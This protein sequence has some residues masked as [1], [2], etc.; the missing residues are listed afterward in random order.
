MDRI[1]HE[2]LSRCLFEESN[3][4]FFIIDPADNRTLDANP[5]AQR[6]TGMRRKQLL[7][8]KLADLLRADVGR[9]VD[10]LIDAYQSTRVFHSEEGYFL[11]SANGDLPINIS[12]SRIHTTP[13]PL[14]LVV[15]RDITRRKRAE[16]ILKSSQR[17]LEI[18]FEHA[19]DAYYLNDLEGNFVDGNKAAE[20]ISGFKKEELIGKNFFNLN[21]LPSTEIPKAAELLKRNALGQTTGPDELVLNRQDGDQVHVEIRTF[22][23][24]IE[25]KDLVL[26]ISRDVTERKR[27]EEELQRAHDELEIRVRQRTTELT[28]ANRR[29]REEIEGRN[30]AAEAQRLME[31][32]LVL[33]RSA[34]HFGVWEWD[35]QTN[36]LELCVEVFT[37]LGLPTDHPQPSMDKFFEWIHPDDRDRVMKERERGLVDVAPYE[38]EY[39]VVWPDDSVHWVMGKG[40]VLRDEAGKPIRALGVLF[41]ITARK[42]A[43]LELKLAKEK[44][45]LRVQERTREL[46]AANLL[47]NLE[48]KE[49]GRAENEARQHLTELAHFG[50]V[51]TIGEMASG[52]SHELNQPLTAIALESEICVAK[53]RQGSAGSDERLLSRLE[54]INDQAHRAGEIIRLLK[55]FTRRAEPCLSTADVNELVRDM[56]QLTDSELQNHNIVTRLELGENLPEVLLDHVQ[57]MQVLLNLVRNAVEAMQQSEPQARFLTIRTEAPADGTIT[58]SVSDTGA[59]IAAGDLERIFESFYTT[60][61]S[62]TGLGLAISRSLIEAHGGRLWANPNATV[63]STLTLRLPIGEKEPARGI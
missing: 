17:R 12:I 40:K 7:G 5:T 10:E 32:R 57:I 28:A 8:M 52:I 50:R 51:S 45:E 59:G 42:E 23:V 63:G 62:G 6:L 4:A 53:I 41:D 38:I 22:P 34:A 33:T 14:G 56:L 29:L 25:G 9:T 18:L 58:I 44:L 2:E 54:W 20:R 15:V 49:R 3:D 11:T 37:L 24:R 31:E 43:E 46:T 55:R 16:E 1:N 47:L 36:K 48:I 13:G 30:R 21:L 27:A 26:C 35:I 19:P 60:K 39:R 61:H